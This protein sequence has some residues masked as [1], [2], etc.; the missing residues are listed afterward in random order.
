MWQCL[1]QG[2]MCAPCTR[3]VSM[4]GMPMHIPGCTCICC[5]A[6]HAVLICTCDAP[7]FV[8]LSLAYAR[9]C[10]ACVRADQSHQCVCT[11]CV[12]HQCV[13]V[14]C[15]SHQCL[16]AQCVSHQCKWVTTVLLLGESIQMC[17]YDRPDH[18][19][20][21]HC[22]SN[23]GPKQIQCMPGQHHAKFKTQRFLFLCH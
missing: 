18:P 22:L 4:A 19:D 8:F 6:A 21:F 2:L 11:Q 5:H 9:R 7:R 16:C 14:Q 23:A 3:W 15:V 20:L 17:L 12:S 10:N 13:C 1:Q